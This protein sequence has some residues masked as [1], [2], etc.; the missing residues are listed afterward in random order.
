MQQMLVVINTCTVTEN[1]DQDAK[2]LVNKCR[3]QNDSVKIA[4]VG[5]LSQIQK[6]AL[7]TWPNVHWVVGNAEKMNLPNI[8]RERRLYGLVPKMTKTPFTVPGTSIDKRHTRANLKIQ[9]GC[10]FYCSFCVI[11]FARGPARSREYD[12]ILKEA[13]ELARYGHKELVLTGVNIGTYSFNDYSF[14]DIVRG[15]KTFQV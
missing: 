2:R 13:N 8:I 12:D 7:L 1:G 11:P 9:D 14:F 3:R 10:D 4:L 6:D 5:C 15:L